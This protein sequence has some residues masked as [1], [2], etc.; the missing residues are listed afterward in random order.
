VI[1]PCGHP[2]NEFLSSRIVSQTDGHVTVTK[3]WCPRCSIES[4][5]SDLAE[6]ESN[7][8]DLEFAARKA[9]AQLEVV[10]GGM[11]RERQEA[12]R[13]LRVSLRPFTRYAA[14]ESPNPHTTPGSAPG[15]AASLAATDGVPPSHDGDGRATEGASGDCACADIGDDCQ[16]SGRAERRVCAAE[17]EAD[18]RKESGK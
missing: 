14:M 4:I 12:I 15:R 16:C 10:T 11:T 8:D 18:A 5:E 1:A 2:Y 6:L 9:L 17:H 7:A 13:D 3:P